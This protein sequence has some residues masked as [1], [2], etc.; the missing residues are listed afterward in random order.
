MAGHSC[1]DLVFE[2]DGAA[3][4]VADGVASLARRPFVVRYI[5]S[6]KE[7][8]L[9]ISTAP[10][11][12]N[13]LATRGR[14]T[15]WTSPAYS[16]AYTPLDLPIRNDFRLSSI[17]RARADYVDILGDKDAKLVEARSLADSSLDLVGAIPKVAANFQP[18]AKGGESL[19]EVRTLDSR[20]MAETSIGRLYVVYFGVVEGI[21]TVPEYPKPWLTRMNWGSCTLSLG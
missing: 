7:P 8:S 11:L 4:P 9:N 1:G 19:Y 13:V 21:A 15:L 12:Q 20:P 14:Q 2:Q 5:G 18:S 16:L 3:V 6:G 17:N 10:L